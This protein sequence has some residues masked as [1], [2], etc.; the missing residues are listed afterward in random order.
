MKKYLFILLTLVVTSFAF[1]SCSS[2]DDD[3]NQYTSA[4]VGTWKLTEVRMSETGSYITWPF[5][6]TYA[7]FKSDGTY[8]GSGYFGTGSGTWSLKGNTIKTYVDGKLYVSYDILSV[9]STEA[10]LKM[11]ADDASL[12]IKCKKQ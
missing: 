7:S 11:T 6:T 9:T 2:D 4:I 1:V 8:Y 5:K 10:E 3:D 12:W